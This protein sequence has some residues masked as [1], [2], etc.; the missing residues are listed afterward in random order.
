MSGKQIGYVRVSTVIQNTE[1]Q[2]YGIE[3]DKVFEDRCSGKDAD[4]PQLKACLEY[5][6]DGDI[7][8]CHSTDRLARN[9]QDLLNIVQVLLSRGISIIFHKEN[10][11]FIAG[12]KDAFQ[13]FQL[14][15]LGAVASFE[16]EILL[17][18]QKEG[19][20]LARKRN[21]YANCGRKKALTPEQI[22]EICQRIQKG[23][24][25][26]ALAKEYGIS[27]QTIYVYCR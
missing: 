12:K 7:L 13:E 25:V 27:R 3:L 11:K 15:I 4:R 21:A 2:L 16:R 1:R 24:K 23:E 10:M 5:L 26:T 20:A 8:Y 14:S 6:R 18:R 22:K 9:L 17:E 19:I